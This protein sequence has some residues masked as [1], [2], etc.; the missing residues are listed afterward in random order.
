MEKIINKILSLL[1]LKLVRVSKSAS[2]QSTMLGAMVRYFEKGLVPKTIIDV[3]AAE[4]NWTLDAMK[5]WPTS[6]YLL[7]EP[8]EERKKQLKKMGDTYSNVKYVQAGAGKEK[9]EVEFYVTNDLDG[10]GI[11]DNGTNAKK[12]II[13]IT[14]IDAEVDHLKLDGPFLVKLDTHGFEVPILEGAEKTLSKTKL[15]IIECYG[16]RI[17]PNSLLFWEMCEYMEKKGFKLLEFVDNVLREKDNAFWQCDAF[18]IPAND[19]IFS[20]NTYH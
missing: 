4:G 10:S 13:P 12:I 15:V 8:L 11:A 14:T 2:K 3:G 5:F 20:S 6:N 7:F 1:N 19:P 9:G 16:L 17:A 18:F